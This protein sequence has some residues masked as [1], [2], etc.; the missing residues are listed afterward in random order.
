MASSDPMIP[1]LT[2]NDIFGFSD[3]ELV[4]FMKQNRRADG[5]FDLGEVDGWGNLAKEQRDQLARR[6]KDGAL[7]AND[8]TQSC[9]VDLDGVAARLREISDNQDALPPAA[10]RSPRYERSPTPFE[11]VAAETKQS[12]TVAYHELVSDGGRPLYHISLLEEVLDN[13]EGHREMLLPWQD[14][15][16]PSIP[17]GDVFRAQLTRWKAFRNWQKYNRDIYNEE[18]E[19]AAYF[20]KEWR[21]KVES[22]ANMSRSRRQD[23]E[24]A[25]RLYLERF[26]A[27]FKRMQEEKGVDEGEAGFLA[28]VEDE[29]RRDLKAGH[30]WP[31]MTEDEYRQTLRVWF[32]QDEFRRYHEDFLWLREDN[33]RGGFP[34]YAAEA[35]RRLAKHGF[36]RTFQLD[37]D[38]ARQD[39]MTTWIEYLN[40]EYSWHDRYE[41]SIER[42]RPEYDEAWKQL[43]DS[44][45]LRPGETDET[46]RTTESSFRRAS[47]REQAEKAVASAETAAKAVFSETVRAKTGRSRFTKQK[48]MQ[49]LATAYSR[50]VGAKEALKTIKRRGDLITEF[51]RGTWDYQGAKRNL[52]RQCLLLQWVL[53]QVPLIEAELNEPKVAEGGSRA[54]RCGKRSRLHQ[55]EQ[56]TDDWRPRKRKRGEFSA[57]ADDTGSSAQAGKPPKRGQHDVTTYGRRSKRLRNDRQGSA[58]QDAMEIS[59]ISKKHPP[60]YREESQSK[61]IPPVLEKGTGTDAKHRA[62]QTSLWTSRNGLGT[63][64]QLRRSDRIAARQN[65]SGTAAAYLHSTSGACRR[66]PWK[67]SQD[68]APSSSTGSRKQQPRSP[69]TKIRGT[70]GNSWLDVSMQKGVSKPGRAKIKR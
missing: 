56:D 27:E 38:P 67:T 3:V 18:E 16:L 39:K 52:R 65:P 53:E 42:L 1:K 24:L 49:R 43:V 40:Y 69:A 63:A 55:D 50:L 45:V 51:I 30:L 14:Y 13:P 29:K 34:E 36:T 9:P 70:R 48:R 44:G 2:V 66:S 41:R 22:E 28:F 60:R 11:D 54:G 33:G 23:Q 58:S 35:K 5:G 26:R 6:L 37:K 17:E 15:P 59:E 25:E 64:V 31:G 47:E 57:V 20:E 8:E 10:S 62:G 68:R 4:Q 12:E 19:F 61:V 7:Q 32:N 46:L 21:K